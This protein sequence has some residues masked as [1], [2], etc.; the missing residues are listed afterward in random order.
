M[1]ISCSKGRQD[2]NIRLLFSHSVESDFLWPHGLQ[3]A[4]LP[5]PSPYP[6]T[7]SNSCPLSQWCHSTIS[8]SVIPFSF[9]LQSFPASRAFLMSQLFASGGQGI[10]ASASASVLPM[11]ILDWFPLGWTGLISLPFNGLSRVFCN[12]TVQKHQFFEAQPSYGPSLTSVRDYWKNHSFNYPNL[13]QQSDKV[14]LPFL[15]PACASGISWFTHCW[16]LAWR[17]SIT[18]LAFEM[19]VV[20]W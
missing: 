20:V 11:N 2:V 6:W 17:L 10:G 1:V 8:S 3:H 4:K 5:C 12:T 7:C 14:P 15:N 18:L 13:C 16:I 9:C 19:N